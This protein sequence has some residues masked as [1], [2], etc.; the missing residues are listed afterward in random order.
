M[1]KFFT[2]AIIVVCI[3][4]FA[5]LTSGPNLAQQRITE[6]EAIELREKSESHYRSL[7]LTDAVSAAKEINISEDFVFA[8]GKNIYYYFFHDGM[9]ENMR[10]EFTSEENRYRFLDEEFPREDPIFG[11]TDDEIVVRYISN[12]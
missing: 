4:L 11:V 7:R 9:W 2:A 6:K 8:K 3:V 10:M 1:K 5:W 12:W